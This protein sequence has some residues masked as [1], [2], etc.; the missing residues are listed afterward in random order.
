MSYSIRIYNCGICH[1]QTKICSKCDRGNIY[2]SSECSE[3]ARKESI[4]SAGKRYQQTKKGKLAHAQ[5]QKNYIVRK[6]TQEKM[7]HQGSNPKPPD[8]LLS[9]AEDNMPPEIPNGGAVIQSTIHYCD[10]CRNYSSSSLRFVF[11]SHSAY[12]KKQTMSKK[13]CG[14]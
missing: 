7:T 5:R 12:A 10:F 3:F 14:P 9:P 2:C 6:I 8:V 13:A 11:L 1:K 4:K